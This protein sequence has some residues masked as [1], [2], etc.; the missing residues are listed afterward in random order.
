MIAEVKRA[1]VPRCDS[2][3]NQFFQKTLAQIQAFNDANGTY[4]NQLCP[5]RLVPSYTH[6]KVW[7]YLFSSSATF[8]VDADVVFYLNNAEI[9][10]QKLHVWSSPATNN[11]ISFGFASVGASPAG[12]YNESY[13]TLFGGTFYVASPHRFN[14]TADRAVICANS[15]T[16]AAANFDGTLIIQSQAGL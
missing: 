3:R 6:R 7:A 14:I 8:S 10:R 2:V 9:F 1:Y 15:L 4:P 5:V 11:Q 13:T 16:G 12:S